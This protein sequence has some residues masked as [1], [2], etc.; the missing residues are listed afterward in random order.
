MPA[1]TGVHASQCQAKNSTFVSVCLV[2]MVL[3]V[4]TVKVFY[5]EILLIEY[6]IEFLY[7]KEIDEC[8]TYDAL[9]STFKSPCQN[10]GY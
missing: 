6:K 1:N 4:N 3:Y 7:N 9:T 2:I 5:C 10:N 8:K